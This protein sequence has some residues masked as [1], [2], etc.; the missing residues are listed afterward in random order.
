MIK[1][2]PSFVQSKEIVFMY[3]DISINKYMSRL[4]IISKKYTSKL[5]SNINT[6]QSK[7]IVESYNNTD[8]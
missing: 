5:D 4:G 7:L 2:L 8:I 1:L 6:F 3:W